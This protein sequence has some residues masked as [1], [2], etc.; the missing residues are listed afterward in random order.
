MSTQAGS[1]A[2]DAIRRVTLVRRQ[3]QRRRWLWLTGWIA[4][5]TIWELADSFLLE[6]STPLFELTFDWLSIVVFGLVLIELF[7]RHEALHVA[8][9][10]ALAAEQVAAERR[11]A[12][13]EAMQATARTVAHN[14]NQPLAIIRGYAELLSDE[15]ALQS[16][17]ADLA[18]IIRQVDRAAKLVQALLGVAHYQTVRDAAGT[19]MLDLAGAPPDLLD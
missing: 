10:E 6:P 12:H 9:L 7:R 15:P 18:V 17:H 4:V 11:L 1:G 16:L 5:D 3:W 19:S 8:A 2:D 14:L 13:Q